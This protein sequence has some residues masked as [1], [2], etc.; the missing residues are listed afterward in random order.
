MSLAEGAGELL[1][2]GLELG[3]T[4][5][6]AVAGAGRERRAAAVQEL[7]TPGRDRGL[8]DPLA[9]AGFLDRDLAAQHCQHDAQLVIDRA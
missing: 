7:V 2:L 4:S 3:L 8:R 9:A 5:A 1:N 6:W